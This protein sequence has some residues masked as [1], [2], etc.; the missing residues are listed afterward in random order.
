MPPAEHQLAGNRNIQATV[1]RPVVGRVKN[2]G[3]SIGTADMLD[4]DLK[5]KVFCY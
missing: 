4:E 1:D 2:A 5:N 3:D